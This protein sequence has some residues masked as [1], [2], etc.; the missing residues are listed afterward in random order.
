MQSSPHLPPEPSYSKLHAQ[1]HI[2][3]ATKA[4]AKA[5][6]ALLNP[7][8]WGLSIVPFLLAAAAWA[9]IALLA[10]DP[11]SAAL[12]QL[13]SQINLPA[14][15]FNA[16]P[17]WLITV[18]ESSRA[19]WIPFGLLLLAIPG[20]LITALSLVGFFGTGIV[21]RRI[22]EQYGLKPID[23]TVVRHGLGFL[24]SVWHSVWVLTALILMWAITLPLWLLPGVSFVLPVVLLGWAT[25][26]LFSF[27][28]LAE[29]ADAEEMLAIR[30]AHGRSVLVLGI[31][32]SLPTVVP[33]MLWV[34]GAFWFVVL[35]LSAALAVWLYVMMFLASAALFSHYLLPAL[36]HLRDAKAA[37]QAAL[38]KAQ[39]DSAA[40]AAKLASEQVHELNTIADSAAI[41]VEAREIAPTLALPASLTP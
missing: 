38:D 37:Q 33:A 16:M 8:L 6:L 34:G 15:L 17:S 41:E 12:R 11:A 40:H 4:L 3:L 25:A 27:D 31:L 29:F 9:G 39:A 21:A 20:V 36:K 19:V 23:K 13:L 2:W 26:R 1:S 22:G 30:T 28:V 7:K 10:W 24:R 5:S 35:P 18:A 14:W 32:A